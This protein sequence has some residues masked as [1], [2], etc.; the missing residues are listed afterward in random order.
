MAIER[1]NK[2][3]PISIKDTIY[4]NVNQNCFLKKFTNSYTYV[5]VIVI[6]TGV[7]V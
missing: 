2:L 7:W 5:T 4:H 6:I 1:D 3:A